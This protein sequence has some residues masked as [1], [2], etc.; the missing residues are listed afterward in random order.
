MALLLP[1]RVRQSP[2]RWAVGDGPPGEIE[3]PPHGT[4]TVGSQ[5]TKTGSTPERAVTWSSGETTDS[6]VPR[7]FLLLVRQVVVASRRFAD[8]AT[9]TNDDRSDQVSTQSYPVAGRC[10]RAGG[11]PG[12]VRS[13][14]ASR[15][16]RR[17]RSERWFSTS[18][19]TSMPR[20]SHTRGPSGR[21]RGR[22]RR[23]GGARRLRSRTLRGP[24]RPPS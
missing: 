4:A 5:S 16:A 18:K 2:G 13:Q 19:D 12:R 10:G 7:R 24:S 15:G 6:T 8:R 11:P 1:S 3:K 21:G 14:R 17:S 9:E 22:K 20:A 23:S